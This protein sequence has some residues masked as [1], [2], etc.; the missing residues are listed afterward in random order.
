[1][2]SV[3]FKAFTGDIGSLHIYVGSL[4]V[5]SDTL[6]SKCHYKCFEKERYFNLFGEYKNSYS[7]KT[8]GRVTK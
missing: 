1:M 7:A 4:L 2:L 8:V 5:F 6:L 3:I